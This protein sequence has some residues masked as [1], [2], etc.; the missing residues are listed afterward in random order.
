M[1]YRAYVR[2]MVDVNEIGEARP[3]RIYWTDGRS[4]EVDRLVDV[5][6]MSAL[7]AGGQG[8]RYIC[9]IRGR[10]V[11]LFEDGGRW[12]LEADDASRKKS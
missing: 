9:R 6:R 1:A 12:F 5:R 11:F 4:F 7:C 3:V 8:T 2:V 10:Q